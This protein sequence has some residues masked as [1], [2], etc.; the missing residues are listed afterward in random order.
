MA[1]TTTLPRP[2]ARV[3]R[4]TGPPGIATVAGLASRRLPS[5]E[6]FTRVAQEY[7][8]VAH[9]RMFGEHVYFLT[10]PDTVREV[11]VTNGRFTIK[12]RALQRSKVLLGEGLLTSEG[13]LWKRQRRLV[14]PAFHA[15]RIRTYAEQMVTTTL[16]HERDVWHDGRE[17]D[18]VAD[19]SALTLTV[20]GRTLF[21][22]DLSGD[23]GDVGAALTEILT[24]FQRQVLPG[25][26]LLERLPLPGV[27]RGMAAIAQLDDVVQRL[28]DEHRAAGD[29]GDVLSM[30]LSARDDA[31][32]TGMDD[33]Q[34]RDEV[35]TLVLAG[36]ETTAMALSWTFALL[37][38]NPAA[39]VALHAELD[40]VLG[41]RAPT[42][43]DLGRLPVTTA[44]FA[45]SMRLYPPA[46]TLGRRLTADV[47]VDGWTLPAGSLVLASQWVLHRD[48]RFWPDAEEY[49][50]Q[51]WIDGD[52]RFDESAPGQPR[53][54]WF[55]FGLGQRMCV[56]EPFAWAEG[57]LV[58][59]TLAQH[60]APEL[61]DGRVPDVDP[62]VTLRPKGGLP[63]VLRRR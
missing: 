24:H 51:R 25:A 6:V 22:A 16:E 27:R 49:L 1:M 28:V 21:G 54:A 8:R 61:T 41:G 23:A 35:M 36:H 57:V 31:D 47:V 50:P 55:P 39:A 33:R 37:A 60:W 53:T 38:T 13:E 58:L 20:V 2:A 29:T 42:Y 59:A 44:T 45:E 52:G 3:S 17:L 12:G 15:A 48:P 40:D 46:W 11:Y 30:L 7:P 9:T 26:Q 32:G 56:G 62:A 4:P 10:H 63:A 18:L 34:V 43:D 19:L 5:T 14:Q